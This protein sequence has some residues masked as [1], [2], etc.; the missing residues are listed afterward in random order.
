MM[1][2]VKEVLGII[3]T[4]NERLLREHGRSEISISKLNTMITTPFDADGVA[5]KTHDKYFDD[6]TS[7]YYQMS[8]EQIKEAWSDKA[9]TSCAYGKKLDEYIGM[10]LEGEDEKKIML[11]KMDNNYDY[12][13]RLKGI[14]DGFDQYYKWLTEETDYVFVFR[15]NPLYYM[16][17]DVMANGRPDAIFYSPSKNKL[18]INDWKNTADITFVNKW[19]RLL[20]PFSNLDDCNG[21]TYTFQTHFY[22]AS[23]ANTYDLGLTEDDIDTQIVQMLQTPNENGLNYNVYTGKIPYERRNIDMLVDFGYKKSK[24]LNS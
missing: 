12:D 2:D 24:L 7:Q 17:G 22:K 8:V 18:L 5:I 4:T 15:E 11:W 14:C 6:E 1:K 10:I 13:T 23:M 9:A 16:V 20:G 3:K 21:N 19:Q